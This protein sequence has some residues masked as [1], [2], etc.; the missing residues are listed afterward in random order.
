MN[1][2]MINLPLSITDEGYFEEKLVEIFFNQLEDHDFGTVVK[3]LD[4]GDIAIFCKYCDEKQIEYIVSP[5]DQKVHDMILEH[6]MFMGP[7]EHQE[8]IEAVSKILPQV[9]MTIKKEGIKLP[10]DSLAYQFMDHLNPVIPESEIVYREWISEQANLVIQD[11]MQIKGLD[12]NIDFNCSVDDKKKLYDSGCV[13]PEPDC[14]GD[15]IPQTGYEDIKVKLSKD[16]KGYLQLKVLSLLICLLEHD[17]QVERVLIDAEEDLVNLYPFIDDGV[18]EKIEMNLSTRYGIALLDKVGESTPEQAYDAARNILKKL[19]R[20]HLLED[21]DLGPFDGII[22]CVN[23]MHD[24]Q[25]SRKDPCD[26]MN[27]SVKRYLHIY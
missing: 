27:T 14:E 16:Q 3:S 25:P 18:K 21:L 2:V 24:E 13:K 20:I 10:E 5:F 17:V 22:S 15:I 23:S 19:D 7:I 26:V 8:H 12:F 4:L 9:V 6:M 11:Y 1:K